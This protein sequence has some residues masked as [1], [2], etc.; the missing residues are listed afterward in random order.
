MSWDTG[1]KI[2][3]FGLLGV[4]T[5]GNVMPLFLSAKGIPE[6]GP[7]GTL[8]CMTPYV[9][10]QASAAAISPYIMTAPR[11]LGGQ[12]IAEHGTWYIGAK[13][14]VCGTDIGKTFVEAL[15]T[16]NYLE[17]HANECIFPS[18]CVSLRECAVTGKTILVP[19]INEQQKK[20]VMND[21]CLDCLQVANYLLR[22][23]QYM[24]RQ[25]EVTHGELT[26]GWGTYPP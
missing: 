24:A 25:A 8:E 19:G 12:L 4:M 14:I 2:M 17:K 18:A 5:L 23:N 26:A 21:I 16:S 1:I 10:L 7:Y 13:T 6:T 20:A 22:K 11:G 9:K 3:I 15:V